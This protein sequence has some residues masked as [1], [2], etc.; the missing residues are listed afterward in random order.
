MFPYT[1]KGCAA[2]IAYDRAIHTYSDFA[3]EDLDVIS[4]AEDNAATFW[5]DGLVKEGHSAAKMK[6]PVLVG[7]GTKDWL[8]PAS[9]QVAKTI[10]HATI[11]LYPDASHGFLFQYEPDWSRLVLHFLNSG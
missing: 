9:K 5:I 8:T 10:P 3:K 2:S 1:A 4:S 11:K 7:D 6:A